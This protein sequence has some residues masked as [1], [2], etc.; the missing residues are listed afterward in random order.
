MKVFKEIGSKER[1]VDM[2]QKVNKVRLNEAVGQNYNP[3]SVLDFAFSELLNKKLTIKH[4][5]TQANGNES[6]VEL[7]CVDSSG[8]NITFTFKAIT[9]EG[10]Q[11]GVYNVDEV[12]MSGFSFDD[13]QGEETIELDEN[14]LR[15]FNAQHADEYYDIVDEYMDVEDEEP[16]MDEMY[17][18][19]VKLIDKVPY[20]AGSER[21][22]KH[23][24]YA[25]QKPTNSAVRVNAPELQKFVKEDSSVEEM[26]TLRKTSNIDMDTHKMV[27]VHLWDSISSTKVAV[28][29]PATHKETGEKKWM[30][31]QKRPI[32]FVE[33]DTLKR[34]DVAYLQGQ[35]AK[36][37]L[38]QQ[39]YRV[40]QQDKTIKP[41]REGD[42]GEDDV[43]SQE[44]KRFHQEIGNDDNTEVEDEPIDNEP[45]EE[46]PEEKKKLILQAYDN[47]MAKNIKNPSY[48][49]TMA[50]ISAE[51]NR[52]TGQPVAKKNR[53]FPRE[54]EPFMES[55]IM[56]EG[57]FVSDVNAN[58]IGN[59][60]YE[61]MPEEKKK[62]YISLAVNQIDKTLGAENKA[63]LPKDEYF[64]LVKDIA[65]K[66]YKAEIGALNE[67]D[68]KSDYPKELGKE[69][70]PEK[71][72]NKTPKKHS[73]KIKIKEEEEISG[74]EGIA[75]MK[76]EDQIKSKNDS[77]SSVDIEQLAKEKEEQGEV[78]QG[79][80]GDGTSPLE[81]D[82]DQ[83][84]KGLEVEMEHTDD[85]LVSIEIVLDHLTEDPE[86][87]TRKD[88]P[89]ASAQQ[90]AAADVSG[91]NK[92]DDT[93]MTDI[94]LG[95]EPKNVGDEPQDEAYDFAAQEVNY[96]N[97]EGYQ[98]YLQ[99]AQMPF[100]DLND[101]QKEEF[102]G[103]WQQFK[104]AEK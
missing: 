44:I 97:E 2:F 71:Q 56:Y 5:N 69:F 74:L 22:I 76:P 49:P 36:E 86:Y 6:Y 88:N 78:L 14:G 38:A 98:K 35:A 3:N 29:I 9:S 94:L 23:A 104:G 65:M 64:K 84:L 15:Q 99:Y 1:F 12:L 90:G 48:S 39:G 58:A 27:L 25:D 16:E 30:L 43:P 40:N 28:F 72:Y 60:Y 81:F 54:A 24:Q 11:D 4:S 61:N 53:V 46:V 63:M 21:M 93:E 10:D 42:Y 62:R 50:D 7:L 91:E 102:F 68:K 100:D 75:N 70:S 33:Y 92:S 59:A 8:N 13:A 101:E 32:A 19:A 103:L 80:K 79:G 17:E 52:I 37:F 77:E 95:Y 45:V 85:P 51:L 67:D 18:D 55:E 41:L 20:K 83:I 31:Y 82:P 66:Y 34:P 57:A 96:D 26:A 47:L 89:E 73:K 87:Y